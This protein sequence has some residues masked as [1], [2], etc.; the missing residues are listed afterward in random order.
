MK[1]LI[2][3]VCVYI[4]CICIILQQLSLWTEKTKT[5]YISFALLHMEASPTQ[6]FSLLIYRILTNFLCVYIS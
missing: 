2:I 5:K 6:V 1:D 4:Y 3:Y